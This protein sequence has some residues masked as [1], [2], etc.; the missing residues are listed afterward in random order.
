MGLWLYEETQPWAFSLADELTTVKAVLIARGALDDDA[1]L[2][3]DQAQLGGSSREVIDLRAVRL[4]RLG[5]GG[6]DA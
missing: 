4:A 3:S 6:P 1:D 2:P 5:D